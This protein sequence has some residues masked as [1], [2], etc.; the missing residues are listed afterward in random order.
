MPESGPAPGIVLLHEIFGVTDWIKN[1]ADLFAAQGY[2]VLAP[3]IFWRLERNFYAD[4][5]IP[6]Q[7]HRGF[8]YRGLI[9]HDKAIA[10]IAATIKHLKSHPKCNGRIGVTGFCTGG[11]LAFLSAARLNIDAAASYYGTQIHEFITE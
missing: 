5:K 3:E 4:F 2:C 8:E 10:D 1:T 6:E 11:T 9:N 7:R